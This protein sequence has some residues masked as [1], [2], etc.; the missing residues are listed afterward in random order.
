MKAFKIY[1]PILLL[2]TATNLLSQTKNIT[3][4]DQIWMGYFNQTKLSDKWGIWLDGQL[5]TQDDFVNNLYVGIARVGGIY[6]LN[7]NCKIIVGYAFAN[8]YPAEKHSM[9]SQIE[10]RPWQQIQWT[11]AYGANKLTQSFRFEER[12]IRNVLND[13]TLADSYKFNY[14]FR[15]HINYQVPLNKKEFVANTFSLVV[16]DDVH[17]NLGKEVV[18]NVFDQ[19]RF[20][21]GVGYYFNS[22]DYVQFGYMNVFQQQAQ[23]GLYKSSNVIR[24]TFYQNLNWSHKHHL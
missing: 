11:T 7:P 9:V 24:A 4:A 21:V 16:S 23:A 13:S 14:R 12:F 18:N 22:Q 1:L 15:Y 19:N 8:Y 2:F 5:R 17:F 20:F 6:Y 3:H 10:H